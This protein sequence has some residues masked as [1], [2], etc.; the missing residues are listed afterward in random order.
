MKE[1][2]S[3][4]F[5]VANLFEGKVGRRKIAGFPS[6]F[7]F[8][9]G[10]N[11]LLGGRRSKAKIDNSLHVTEVEATDE[12]REESRVNFRRICEVGHFIHLESLLQLVD[13]S[14]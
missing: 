13:G 8:L 11:S 14:V 4:I 3:G 9:F 12:L 2:C 10:S 7:A 5:E 1:D 6:D